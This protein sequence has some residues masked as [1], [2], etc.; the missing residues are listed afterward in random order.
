M[1]PPK[2]KLCQATLR[3]GDACT[4]AALTGKKFCGTHQ[5][6]AKGKT[7]KKIEKA[8]QRIKKVTGVISAASG[9]YGAVHTVVQH[10]PTILHSMS[11]FVSHFAGKGDDE[12]MNSRD[13]YRLFQTSYEA[14]RR[15]ETK[16]A[17]I[18][19]QAD[20]D[21][22]ASQLISDARIVWVRSYRGLQPARDSRIRIPPKE[23]KK[24]L[25]AI[26]RCFSAADC[27]AEVR[28]KTA[29]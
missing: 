27:Y 22:A 24:F 6:Q 20:F 26:Q 5:R 7:W 4:R 19:A 3:T 23:K 14:M 2:A 25:A 21:R 11:V 16:D 13:A 9:L 8:G 10:W 1:S 12:G 29:A 17:F 28:S 15:A 18:R